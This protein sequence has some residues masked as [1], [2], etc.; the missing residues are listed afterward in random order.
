MIEYDSITEQWGALGDYS[1][2]ETISFSRHR[3]LIKKTDL[4]PLDK[5]FYKGGANKK[6]TEL[7]FENSKIPFVVGF[8]GGMEFPIHGVPAECVFLGYSKWSWYVPPATEGEVPQM[9]FI[10]GKKSY[11]PWYIWPIRIFCYPFSC[12]V[13]GI[14]WVSVFNG[15]S[16][17]L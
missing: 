9:A 2:R 6:N 12:I 7:L 11:S 16:D 8:S 4:L 10:D 14:Y 5:Y 13:E 3:K 15:N 17:A 1:Q